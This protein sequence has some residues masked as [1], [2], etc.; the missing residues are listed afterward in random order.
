MG[1]SINFYVLPRNVEHDTSKEF[2]FNWEFQPDEEDVED[3]IC[4]QVLGVD[5]VSYRIDRHT[6]VNVLYNNLNSFDKEEEIKQKWCPKCF[7]YADGFYSSELIVA[8]ENVNHSYSNP[9]WNSKWN[10]K[11]LYIGSSDTLF[12]NK[13]RNDK[14]YRE[15]SEWDVER[16]LEN[17]ADLGE[18]LRNSDKEACAETMDILR[19][20]KSW[21][22]KGNDYIVIVE[23][24]P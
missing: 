4:K 22:E 5:E 10:I 9:I 15:V 2:C 13:F 20:L 23:D 17:I 19:F 11:D 18:P 6:R 1:R 14:L 16:A 21:V 12:I 24:E 3:E 7:M 8:T